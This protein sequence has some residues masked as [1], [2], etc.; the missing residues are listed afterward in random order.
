MSGE[1]FGTT[2]CG[3]HVDYMPVSVVESSAAH[4]KRLEDVLLNVF[5]IGHVG[6]EVRHKTVTK[7]TKGQVA[8]KK[9]QSELVMYQNMYGLPTRRWKWV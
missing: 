6:V 9:P 8:G 2:Y 7:Q 5:F 4:P 1:Q 3:I